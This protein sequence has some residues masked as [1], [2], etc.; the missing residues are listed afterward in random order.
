MP[1]SGK[2]RWGIIGPGGISATLLRD[3]D[4]ASNYTVNA[5]ASRDRTRA[6]A[7]ASRFGIEQVYDTYDD[8]LAD[9]GVDAVYIGLPNSLHH[10]MTMKSLAAGKHV[11]C[12]KP[13]TRH[14]D[15]V[16]MAFTEAATRRLFLME[17]FMWRHRPQ[18]RKFVEL[19]PEIGEL[20]AIRTRFSF[21]LRNQDDVRLDPNL[22]GGALMDVG[23]YSVSGARLIAGEDPVRV[24]GE[25]KLAASGVDEEFAGL[26]RFRSGVVAQISCG[27]TSEGRSLE[28]IGSRATLSIRDPWL[29]ETGG[30][31]LDGKGV[32]VQDADAYRLELENLSAAI[33]GRGEP[34]LGREDA[35]GQARTIEALYRSA[36]T[37]TAVDLEH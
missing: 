19:L 34:L 28:A 2:V 16:E 18:V 25:Q 3:L 1:S 15:E 29:G 23:C 9:P 13:Y 5:V 12:E 33:L 14:P 31:M 22:D 35:R 21:V 30:V 8:L 11:L 32:P 17:A 10:P 27:F 7:F 20:R 36:E 26:L 6:E 24:F 37:G 4:R